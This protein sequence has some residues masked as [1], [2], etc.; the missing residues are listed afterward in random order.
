VIPTLPPVPA[1][2]APLPIAIAP[3]LPELDVP[4]L[5]VSAPLKPAVP[6]FAV[7]IVIAPLVVA[8]PS[9]VVIET[10]PPVTTVL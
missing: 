7:R 3:V 5:N 1:V 2:A 9:P 8:V 6:A 4:E 10:E